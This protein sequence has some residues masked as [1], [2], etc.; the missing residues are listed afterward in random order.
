M[1]IGGFLFGPLS[2]RTMLRGGHHHLANICQFRSYTMVKWTHNL[3]GRYVR[4]FGPQTW[5]TVEELKRRYFAKCERLGS[6]D[7]RRAYLDWW[8]LELHWDRM[9]RLWSHQCALCREPMGRGIDH[10]WTCG[11]SRCNELTAWLQQKRGWMRQ[12][13]RRV[14]HHRPS[15]AQLGSCASEGEWRALVVTHFLEY[16]AASANRKRLDEK[17]RRTDRG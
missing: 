1:A 2:E 17:R 5:A 3:I 7:P 10:R 6:I 4:R 14:R 9:H 8:Q 13:D 11:R 12:W 16:K 15:L